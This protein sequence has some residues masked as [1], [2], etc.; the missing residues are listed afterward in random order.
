MIMIRSSSLFSLLLLLPGLIRAQ[1]SF[2]RLKFAAAPK[3]LPAGART[4]DWPRFLGPAD[5]AVSP[6]T[7]LL[8]EWPEGGPA[9]VWEVRKGDGYTA[10]VVSGDYCVIF[11][12]LEGKETIECLQRET[13]R[14]FWS[15][16]Y[17]IGYKD[18]YGFTPGPRASAVISDGCV[19]TQGVTS[20]LSAVDLKS[21]K[22]LWQHDLATDYN[23]PQDFFGH[24]SSPLIL[25]GRVIVNVGGKE[26]KV[27]EDA[28]HRERAKGLAAKGLSVGAFDLKTGRLLWRVDDD[29]GASYASPVP[30]VIHGKT[31]VLVFAGG[32]SDP[33]TGGLMCIDPADGTLHDKSPWRAAA[34]L[35]ATAMSP[36]VA[37][38]KN[39]VFVSTAYPKNHALGGVMVEYDESFKAKEVWKS[40]KLGIHW[41]NPVYW[42]GY[43][44]AIDGEREDQ[45]R[46][47][48]VNAEDGA[49]KWSQVVQW[50]DAVAGTKLGRSGPVN[51]SILRAALMRVDGAFLCMGEI[52]AL[53]WLDLSP[54]GCKV[55]RRHQL[56]YAQHTWNLPALS[57]G[58]LYVSQ[59]DPELTD[60]TPSR[61]ICYDL[62]GK[63]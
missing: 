1:E 63:Q 47:V 29:W 21:G 42:D 20:M 35:S 50:E 58:L 33:A 32:E 18:R 57:Q 45:A 51:L 24:G 36:V 41:M 6:E 54:Q 19:I 31:K 15:F 13:G 26:A 43:L 12:A 5:D 25:D 14:R 10:P 11:H 16:D 44:Y 48:C 53:L 2:D 56:F 23:V 17:P 37:P 22:L 40:T 34:Y 38:G 46:L 59:N 62:R 60:Q 27:A 7:H 3:A 9:K 55:L 8:H 49:E 52:G 61:F 4:S 30:A 28:P 39:R